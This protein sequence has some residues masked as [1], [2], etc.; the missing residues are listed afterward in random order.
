MD[1]AADASSVEGSLDGRKILHYY[2]SHVLL[3]HQVSMQIWRS[4]VLLV[5]LLEAI[6]LPYAVAFGAGQPV[7][8]LVGCDC[9]FGIDVCLS[10]VT[11][12]R[13][14]VTNRLILDRRA[15]VCHYARTWFGLDVLALLPLWL[16]V[17]LAP[18]IELLKLLR[19]RHLG[20]LRRETSITSKFSHLYEVSSQVGVCLLLLHLCCC[21]LQLVGRAASPTPNLTYGR[22]PAQ[23]VFRLYETFALF[24]GDAEIG[25]VLARTVVERLFCLGL[26]MIGALLIALLFGSV[27]LQL[28]HSSLS[29][30]RFNE[31]MRVVN[32]S[33]HFY[34]LPAALQERTRKRYEYAWKQYRDLQSDELLYALS[35]ALKRDLCLFL[36]SDMLRRVALFEHATPEVI[37]ALAEALRPQFFL[38]KDVLCQE[39]Q[40]GREMYFLKCGVVTIS[41]RARGVLGHLDAGEYFGEMCLLSSK[42][43]GAKAFAMDRRTCTVTAHTLV[44]VMVLELKDLEAVVADYPILLTNM[45]AV[46]S[47][48]LNELGEIARITSFRKAVGVAMVTAC[49][50]KQW[51]KRAR[52]AS[53]ARVRPADATTDTPSAATSATSDSAPLERT[54]RSQRADSLAAGAGSDPAN[55][56]LLQLMRAMQAEMSSL[57]AEVQDLRKHQAA[58]SQ[59]ATE[60]KLTASF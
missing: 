19:L 10:F 27:A 1:A 2:T 6:S 22:G 14:R 18:Y 9:V 30:I 37:A 56:E 28:A 55:V 11:A 34:R 47:R 50:S 13:E 52:L 31:R 8:L 58:Y 26:L 51:L 16:I 20:A 35:P 41:Q 57:R 29:R 48:R 59:P 5:L 43:F 49:Q 53:S 46:A 3:P 25:R 33:M 40:A 54:N 17:S 45:L 44:D 15:I 60:A 23:Y 24:L 36:Y 32:E 7:G 4:V 38:E 21:A 39:G 42:A 12:Y